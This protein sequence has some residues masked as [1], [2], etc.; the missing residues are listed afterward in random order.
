MSEQELEVEYAH[1]LQVSQAI[2]DVKFEEALADLDM[3]SARACARPSTRSSWSG[4]GG[5]SSPSTAFEH[6]R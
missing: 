6:R 1:L 2:S 4:R 3:R 5:M